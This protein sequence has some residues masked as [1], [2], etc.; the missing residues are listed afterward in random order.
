[1]KSANLNMR[2]DPETKTQAERIY[3]DFGITLSDAVNMFLKKS[4]MVGG[5]PFDLTP[6]RYNAET[7]AA[8][9]EGVILAKKLNR[10]EIKGYASTKEMFESLRQ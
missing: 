5:L 7:E 1:M 10:G 6:P 2:I 8:I 9:A 4:V 3:A